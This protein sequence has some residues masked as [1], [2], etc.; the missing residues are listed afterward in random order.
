MDTGVIFL[1]IT[2]KN[3]PYVNPLRESFS[4]IPENDLEIQ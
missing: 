2:E 1:M 3:F 4:L